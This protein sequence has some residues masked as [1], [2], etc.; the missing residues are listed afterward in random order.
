MRKVSRHV[1]VPSGSTY[2]T[3]DSDF[4]VSDQQDFHPTDVIENADGS[5]L[6]LDTGGWY[7]LCCPSSQLVKPDVKG[8][9]YRVKKI[10]SHKVDDPRGAKI[11]WKTKPAELA[12]MLADP[13]PVVRWKSVEVLAQKTPENKAAILAAFRGRSE[14]V[15]LHAVWA[16]GRMNDPELLYELLN[17]TN[18]FVP[19]A[20]HEMVQVALMHVCG[21]CPDQKIREV[22]WDWTKQTNYTERLHLRRAIAEAMG[23]AGNQKHYV[24]VLLDF[25]AEENNDRTL[26]HALTFALI[27]IGDREQVLIGTENKSPRVRR[28]CLTALD[29]MPGGKLDAE[30]VIS[31]LG[32]KDAALNETAW[33]IAG[34]HPEWGEHLVEYFRAEL[35]RS[36]KLNPEA[37]TELTDRL[38]K[39]LKNDA[40]HPVVT[41]S[42]KD[43]PKDGKLIALRGVARS[44][45]KTMPEAW[46]K[47]VLKAVDG[48]DPDVIREALAAVRAVPMDAN[49]YNQLGLALALAQP[50][51]TEQTQLAYLAA[52]P[53]GFALADNDLK[54]VVVKF[55]SGDGT[56]DRTQ[57]ADVL[58]R[59]GL[60]AKQLIVVAL[61][62]RN[63]SPLDVARLLPAFD[64][65]K[66]E[67]VGLALVAALT[68]GKV[69]GVVRIEQVKPILDKYPKTVQAEAEKLYALLAEARKEERGKLEKL[70][71][72]MPA[73]DIRRG[74]AVFNGS[75]AQCVACHKI[76]YVGGLVGPDLTRIGSIRTERDLLE[77]IVFPNAS[78]V[79]SYEP[80][81]VTTGDGRVLNGILKKDAP[82][83][84]ILTIAA[85]KEERISRADVED[86]SPGSVS[87]M[88]A[89]LDQQLS[90]QELADLVAF[91]RACK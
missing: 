16:A 35:K 39:F 48:G 33:W 11:D 71:A 72:E 60:S 67:Q 34:R 66:D 77:S 9:I 31:R 12:K 74:Q 26:D 57:V 49:H 90:V 69:R 32:S 76:G 75:K 6:I 4:V 36:D 83:E 3:K 68:D 63:S 38:V 44:G 50:P 10:G 55:A 8:A 41:E 82:D 43:G 61:L 58:S 78:F 30:L 89:G 51:I 79:R 65:S 7:K 46:A 91:L 22:L 27:E 85:D 19:Q 24:S 81:R 13:R 45:V 40:I 54:F 59:R 84:I 56:G 28:A 18:A 42:L 14:I 62:V 17:E 20:S 47:A 5:L 1:L 15:Q 87:V 21:L 52:A 73:G 23:R 29:Q 88:P 2:I 53:P 64:R 70:L 80:V 25:L 37:R 86:I